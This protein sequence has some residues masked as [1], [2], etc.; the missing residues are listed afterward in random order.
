MDS[1]LRKAFLRNGALA[2]GVFLPLF[3]ICSVV[4]AELVAS[5]RN[6]LPNSLGSM[7]VIWVAM[8]IPALLGS[9]LQTFL[10]SLMGIQNPRGV[11]RLILGGLSAL[12]PATVAAM[13]GLLMVASIRCTLLST[14]VYGSLS[15]YGLIK[16]QRHARVV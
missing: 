9:V 8:V 1:N 15:V 2:A 7:L 10:W 16:S 6:S 13:G 4:E 3:S 12:V 11:K 14:L 5:A